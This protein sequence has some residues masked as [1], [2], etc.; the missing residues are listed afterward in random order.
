MDEE[1]RSSWALVL[2]VA[3]LAFALFCLPFG[4]DYLSGPGYDEHILVM[5]GREI[6][7]TLQQVV[8]LGLAAVSGAIGVALVRLH[9][10]QSHRG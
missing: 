3:A 8:A 2:G 6:G 9:R 4:I 1:P 7:T 10:R 5:N